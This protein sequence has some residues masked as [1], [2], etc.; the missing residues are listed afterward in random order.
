RTITVRPDSAKTKTAMDEAFFGPSTLPGGTEYTP[1]AVGSKSS[2]SVYF[3]L[4]DKGRLEM[5]VPTTMADTVRGAPLTVSAQ[6]PPVVGGALSETT[7]A[8]SGEVEVNS[9]DMLIAGRA[10]NDIAVTRT[11]RS[12][13]IGTTPIG[14]GW[15]AP[16]LRRLRQLP[17]GNVE[18]RDGMGE[19]WTF[20]PDTSTPSSGSGA[21]PVATL[22]QQFGTKI[23]YVSPRGL[24]LRLSR[25]D[26]GWMLF[27]QQWRISRFDNYGRLTSE[28]D[29][30]WTKPDP[31]APPS[32]PGQPPAGEIGNTTYFVYDG[33]GRLTQIVDPLGR[34]TDFSYWPAM[35]APNDPLYECIDLKADRT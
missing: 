25:N 20:Y 2:P 15:E 27:D 18:Y 24:H 21:T 14:Q 12:R 33:T 4:A 13:T 17:N 30:F 7:Y 23:R 16:F 11:H 34:K 10:G 1:T 22:D 35:T 32:P 31:K 6:A 3:Y 26:S 19:V 29:E 5:H 28:S 9:T 8:H